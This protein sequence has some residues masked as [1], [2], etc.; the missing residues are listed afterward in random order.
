MEQTKEQLKQFLH[1]FFRK[2]DLQDDD[3]IFAL[4]FVNS[5]FAMQLVMFIETE[6]GIELENQD[7]H[8]DNFRSINAILDLIRTKQAV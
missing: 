1:R 8:L 5:L 7:I 3:D 4:G 6:L 2:P